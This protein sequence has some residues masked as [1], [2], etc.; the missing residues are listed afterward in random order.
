MTKEQIEADIKRI[1]E[2]NAE[3]EGLF[4][5]FLYRLFHTTV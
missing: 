3:D 4:K 1:K 2:A 5:S